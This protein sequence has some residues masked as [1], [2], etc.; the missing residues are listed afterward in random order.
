MKNSITLFNL[1][2]LY[3][4]SFS[5]NKIPLKGIPLSLAQF[6]RSI[7]MLLFRGMYFYRDF[8]VSI[9]HND[10]TL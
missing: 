7:N 5:S 9:A 6:I 1:S 3:E 10:T 2:N 8:G 4:K